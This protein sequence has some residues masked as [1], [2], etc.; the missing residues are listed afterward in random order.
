MKFEVFIG[1][2]ALLLTTGCG[3][4]EN[5]EEG[6]GDGLLKDKVTVTANEF[7]SDVLARR[8]KLES[9]EQNFS[10]IETTN[11]AYFK[12][13]DK[14][15]SQCKLNFVHTKTIIDINQAERTFS[16]YNAKKWSYTV[17]DSFK[18]HIGKT[19]TKRFIKEAGSI[20][21][22]LGF[23]SRDVYGYTVEKGKESGSTLYEVTY[24]KYSSEF[25]EDIRVKVLFD[26]ARPLFANPVATRVD[27]LE[28]FTQVITVRDFSR[29]NIISDS[30][31]SGLNASKPK[32]A[33]SIYNP[34]NLSELNL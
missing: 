12:K 21:F 16:Q 9:L 34:N 26:L 6:N 30:L 20:R 15:L 1:L 11:A 23:D 28:S 13:R 2:L 25:N 7:E 14:S 24:R 19:I 17:C 27:G 4:E 31:R 8:D 33:I 29:R 3:L 32:T 10:V 22:F 18:N 5:K